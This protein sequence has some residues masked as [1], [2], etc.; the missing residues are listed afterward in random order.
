MEVSLGVLLFML[1]SQLH[2]LDFILSELEEEERMTLSSG[3]SLLYWLFF[4]F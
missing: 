3:N 4:K 2:N 1:V